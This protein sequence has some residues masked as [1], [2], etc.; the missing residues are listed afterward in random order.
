MI[1]PV[2]AFNEYVNPHAL[3]ALYYGNGQLAAGPRRIIDAYAKAIGDQLNINLINHN[4]KQDLKIILIKEEWEI[5]S[6]V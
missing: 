6:R 5:A 4:F 2:R 3:K 1:Y